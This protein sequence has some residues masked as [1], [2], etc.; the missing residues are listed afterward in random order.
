[1]SR[2]LALACVALV[3]TLGAIP[4][5][6][7]VPPSK[8]YQAFVQKQAAELRKND[9]APASLADWTKQETALRQKLFEA[10]GSEACFLPKPC[11]LDPQQH[12][13]PLKRDGYTVEKL[14]IQTRPGV[15][16]TCNLYVPDGAKKKPEL[17]I[18]Q[19]GSSAFFQGA[20]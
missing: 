15:R 20:G 1:M 11:D 6:D 8:Q 10:W 2:L 3:A 18:T 14:T 17:L 16:M 9:K 12:G 13:E 4:A 7:D 5:A 19:S